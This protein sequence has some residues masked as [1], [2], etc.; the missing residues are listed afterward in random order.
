[1]CTKVNG[2]DGIEKPTPEASVMKPGM[3]PVPL[4]KPNR[5]ERWSEVFGAYDRDQPETVEALQAF[6]QSHPDIYLERT[7][8]PL[9]HT[10]AWVGVCLGKD[11]VSVF[12]DSVISQEKEYQKRV[13]GANPSSVEAAL[14]S[15]AAQIWTEVQLLSIRY[16]SALR[17]PFRTALDSANTRLLKTLK[18]LATVRR[19]QKGMEIHVTH[20]TKSPAVPPVRTA[21]ERGVQSASTACTSPDRIA[22][23]LRG[24][25]PHRVA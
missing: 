25:I 14:A 19:L 12:G 8:L 22:H 3:H 6:A 2:G 20:E 15:T 9:W 21:E 1:M 24:L 5:L 4:P 10:A 7:A 16:V 18:V 17:D 13:A 23:R 11:R